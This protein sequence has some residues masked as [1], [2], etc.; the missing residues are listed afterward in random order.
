MDAMAVAILIG[1]LG[2]ALMLVAVGI[3]R[4]MLGERIETATKFSQLNRLRGHLRESERDLRDAVQVRRL[5]R[6]LNLVTTVVLLIPTA[7]A[8][9]NIAHQR[10]ST[11][12]RFDLLG[13]VTLI[14]TK[15]GLFLLTAILIPTAKTLPSAALVAALMSWTNSFWKRLRGHDGNR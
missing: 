9:F 6:T 4:R 5:L 12:I 7:G 15:G 10:P 3:E 11:A 13:L 1:A 8:A 2:V 14:V